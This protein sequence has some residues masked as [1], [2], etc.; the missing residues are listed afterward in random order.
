PQLR[1][2]PDSV[3][4]LYGDAAAL[5][6]LTPTWEKR[7]LDLTRP[8]YRFAARPRPLAAV[9]VLGDRRTADAP[10]VEEWPAAGRLVALSQNT[11]VNYLLDRAMRAAEFAALG[12]LVAAVPMH[13]AV[14]HADPARVGELC[15]VIVADYQ[16]TIGK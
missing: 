1:L 14:A 10:R 9:Y 16:R 2:W 4:V 11:Y 6:P 5:P 3:R 7:G 12:R 15:E 13:R 8:G